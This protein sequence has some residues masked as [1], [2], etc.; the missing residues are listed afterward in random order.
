MYPKDDGREWMVMV[1]CKEREN[2]FKIIKYN[3]I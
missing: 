3:V 1:V 2:I